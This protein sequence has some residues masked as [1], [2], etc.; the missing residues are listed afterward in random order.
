M[1]ARV[2]N[3]RED[4]RSAIAILAEHYSI[5]GVIRALLD[6]YTNEKSTCEGCLHWHLM[7][8][9]R[10]TIREQAEPAIRLFTISKLTK[11]EMERCYNCRDL[12]QTLDSKCPTTEK[13]DII[14]GTTNRN[15]SYTPCPPSI[16]GENPKSNPM[17]EPKSAP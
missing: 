12:M 2:I 16:D 11:I 10:A 14:T 13:E 4:Q 9:I 8:K 3:F 5:S 1:F 7:N 17:T 15:G 6:V